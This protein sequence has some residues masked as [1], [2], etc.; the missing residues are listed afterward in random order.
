MSD[1]PEPSTVL[2][3]PN[4]PETPSSRS[5]ERRPMGPAVT[6][7]SSTR[8][9]SG[10]RQPK[11]GG[12]KGKCGSGAGHQ[13][14]P[15][16][17]VDELEKEP[18]TNAVGL[19]VMSA[20]AAMVTAVAWSAMAGAAAVAVAAKNRGRVR[21]KS[22]PRWNRGLA[23]PW[24]LSADWNSR[25]TTP[26][27]ARDRLLRGQSQEPALARGGTA[28]S[29]SAP[30]PAQAR[31]R[32][33]QRE[34]RSREPVAAR[35]KSVA[36]WPIPDCNPPKIEVASAKMAMKEV[37]KAEQGAEEPTC[38]LLAAG[39]ASQEAPDEE[40]PGGPVTRSRDVGRMPKGPQPIAA[41]G[42]DQPTHV[43]LDMKGAW[44]PCSGWDEKTQ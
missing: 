40:R 20:V 31:G 25:G 14:W 6:S 16:G 37:V 39:A 24:E 38:S 10:V 29:S 21:R 36:R 18:D 19:A 44:R 42:E 7:T 12:G 2:E 5:G 8:A 3:K 22:P 33:P 4:T 9:A 28:V 32:E 27:L 11:A 23:R 43:Y 34:S 13:K 30:D 17:W 41:A 35:E 1:P 15:T 26:G